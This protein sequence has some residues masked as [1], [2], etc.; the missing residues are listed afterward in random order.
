M[1]IW[2]FQL[3]K[4]ITVYGRTWADF[5]KLLDI[6]EIIFWPLDKNEP[7]YLPVYVH[8]LSYEFVFLSGIY[9]FKPEE[10]FAVKKHKV[11]YCRMR[12]FIEFRCSY[13]MTQLSLGKW[14]E[15]LG[16]DAQKERGFDYDKFRTAETPLTRKELLYCVNDVRGLV[17]GIYKEC[18]HG[19]YNMQTLPRTQTGFV[20]KE[21][22][23]AMFEQI[24]NIV[25]ARSLA[26]RD[27]D[28]YNACREEFAGGDTHA[29]RY[30]V[31]EIVDDVYSADLASAYPAKIVTECFPVR[32][33]R[34]VNVG[35]VAEIPY[36]LQG[37]PFIARLKMFNVELKNILLPVPYIHVSKCR[38]LVEAVCDNG[39]ILSA[40]YFEITVN[41][42]DLAIIED[43]Y[44]F[45][46]QIIDIWCST[47]GKMPQPI[48][49]EVMKLYRLKTEL[50]GADDAYIYYMK[51]K[52]KINSMYGMCV[53]VPIQRD[54]LYM[55]DTGEFV[56]D[57]RK[58]DLQLLVEYQKTAWLAYQWGM[59]VTSYVRRQLHDAIKI[60]GVNHVY[61][62]TD[63]IKYVGE[64][65]IN[66]DEFNKPYL[67]QAKRCGAFADDQKGKRH[68]MG[69]F[70]RED[71]YDRF[72]TLGAKKYAYE[73]DEKIGVTVAGV[74]KGAPY[75]PQDDKSNKYY[76]EKM[77]G[78]KELYQAGGLAN[79]VP[80]F[81]FKESGGS[82]AVYNINR[83]PYYY[84]TKDG[85]RIL[86]T[87]NLYIEAHE[88]SLGITLE[89]EN[90]VK[91]S[92]SFYNFLLD[93]GHYSEL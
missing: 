4:N 41:E 2:Q 77:T 90:I 85:Q 35:N 15:R 58:T 46:S 28:F 16:V 43:I 86:L 68:Y 79:F 91:S 57:M 88:Y 92:S 53:Q 75:C 44:E 70:E 13:L 6:L 55:C 14:L 18:E 33:F 76:H 19:E 37:R 11:L 34:R 40:A 3:G 38:E 5:E 52:E 32:P 30:Y 22:K 29:N 64:N 8:N 73:Q 63:S 31:G 27:M 60:L 12:Q 62:D 10:V 50:K 78:G 1:Y 67:Q 93:N 23:K 36:I 54:L 9:D 69:I 51:S 17:Q 72:I 45:D 26:P 48:I 59:W 87:A 84:L 7:I 21:C 49:D 20:R 56:E 89:Y 47:Y 61:N 83:T 71:G 66:L 74:R 82:Q 25:N 39:R 65:S 24:Y 42:Q 80:G 81:K